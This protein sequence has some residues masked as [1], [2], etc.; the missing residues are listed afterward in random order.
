MCGGAEK[1]GVFKSKVILDC[2]VGS[3]DTDER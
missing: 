3:V 1:S 2:D